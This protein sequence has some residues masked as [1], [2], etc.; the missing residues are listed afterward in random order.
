MHETGVQ[1]ETCAWKAI[2]SKQAP[3]DGRVL[4]L[5]MGRPGILNCNRKQKLKELNGILL[6]MKTSLAEGM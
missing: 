4:L 5:S 2:R 3:G 6:K 1:V